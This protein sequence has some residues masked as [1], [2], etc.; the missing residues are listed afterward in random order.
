MLE[1]TLESP[2]D[3]KEIQPVHP[4]GNQFWIFIGRTDA[5]AETLVLWPP[6]SKNWL[7]WKDPDAEKDWRQEEK[8]M[9]E[10]EMVRWHHRLNEHGFG[11]TP[12]VGDGQGGLA[13]RG[14]WGRKESDTTERLNW[15]ELKESACNAGDPGLIPGPGRSPRERNGYPLQYSCLENFMDRGTWWATVHMVAKSRTWLSD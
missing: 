15:T 2:L 7:I 14:S 1:K 5:E 4:K 6:D 12:G 11:W 13:C 8:G 10:D 9:K 3:G